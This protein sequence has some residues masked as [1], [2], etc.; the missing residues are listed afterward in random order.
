MASLAPLVGFCSWLL[1]A[2]HRLSDNRRTGLE[3]CYFWESVIL[4]NW[5]GLLREYVTSAPSRC[6]SHAQCLYNVHSCVDV[7][8][9]A[10]ES[11]HEGRWPVESRNNSLK[12]MFVAEIQESYLIDLHQGLHWHAVP[13][14]MTGMNC[15]ILFMNCTASKFSFIDSVYSAVHWYRI[16]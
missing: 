5:S 11:C 16:N 12:S 10:Y 2:A 15:R 1:L 13:Y 7:Q 9:A 8:S 4:R 6:S 14:G 3:N